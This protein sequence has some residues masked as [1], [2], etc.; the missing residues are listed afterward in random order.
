[1]ELFRD[2]PSITGWF[3]IS[4]LLSMLFI[5]GAVIV[6]FI[7]KKKQLNVPEFSNEI[8]AEKSSGLIKDVLVAFIFIILSIII[9][10]S[11]QS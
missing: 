4:H 11:V 7:L 5:I 3:S 8:E 10:Y 1:M 6:M 2:N 9:F